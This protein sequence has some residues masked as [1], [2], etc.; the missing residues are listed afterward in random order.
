MTPEQLEVFWSHFR[1]LDSERKHFSKPP[2]TWRP[3]SFR[4]MNTEELSAYWNGFRQIMA[5]AADKCPTNLASEQVVPA[6]PCDAEPDERCDAN[7]S[8][9]LDESSVTVNAPVQVTKRIRGKTNPAKLV[10]HLRGIE[11]P[12]GNKK[13]PSAQPKAKIEKP[14]PVK[15]TYKVKS[16]VSRDGKKSSISIWNKV[17]L[18]KDAHL[19]Q[20]ALFVHIVVTVVF[21]AAGSAYNHAPV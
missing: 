18:C 13:K 1:E 8:A 14:K 17:Q 7:P 16:K 5:S 9:A 4:D 20:C 2:S 19:C 21:V 3:P 10:E 11:L 6:E 12:T 15:R